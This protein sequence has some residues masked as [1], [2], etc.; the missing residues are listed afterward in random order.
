MVDMKRG[1]SK[2]NTRRRNRMRE[3]ILYEVDPH[4]RLVSKV[5]GL[6]AP[7]RR[8]RRVLDGTF[9]TGAG[10]TLRYHIKNPLGTADLQNIV[11]SGNW[12]LDKRHNLVFTLDKWNNQWAGNRLV[13]KGEIFDVSDNRISFMIKTKDQGGRRKLYGLDLAGA[14]SA[15]RYNRLTF[16]VSRDR[17]PDCLSFQGAWEVNRQNRLVY[18]YSTTHLKTERKI[19]RTLTFEGSWDINQQCRISYVLNARR[20]S[21]FDFTA[22]IGVPT[23]EAGR[24]GL[25]YEIG[26]G[27]EERARPTRRVI[28]LFGRWKIDK[29]L[30]VVFEMEYENRVRKAIIF[31]ADATLGKGPDVRLMLTNR[32]G[33]P[34]GIELKLSQEILSGVGRAYID[35][36][37]SGKETE[38]S[39]GAG[40]RW[41]AGFPAPLSLGALPSGMKTVPNCLYYIRGYCIIV[42]TEDIL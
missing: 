7:V 31:G 17:S 29:R 8:F 1:P 10:N 37:I 16:R 36:L 6:P 40:M 35:C 22:S 21:S 30:G 39:I 27:S 26:I 20:R 11:F 33:E 32:A 4:N 25:R 24:N 19:E 9:A 14:W 23:Q 28:T 3:K 15:D 42:N 34:L 2:I 41:Y 38:F 5:T 18:T 12:S 13:L